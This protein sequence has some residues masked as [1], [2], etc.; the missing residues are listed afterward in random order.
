MQFQSVGPPVFPNQKE[1]TTWPIH[2]ARHGGLP[3]VVL[4]I[5]ETINQYRQAA[6][7]VPR[8]ALHPK[9]PTHLLEQL[10]VP[11]EL[12]SLKFPFPCTRCDA[13]LA[14]HPPQGVK[15]NRVR[16][17]RNFSIACARHVSLNQNFT[18]DQHQPTMARTV[19]Q[20]NPQNVT[21]QFSARRWRQGGS[22]ANFVTF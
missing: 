13:M 9:T 1:C 3:R 15:L 11:R 19:M 12:W 18:G 4:F 6:A 21:K 8:N 2:F 20:F 22:L 16:F 14:A 5:P 7:L 17:L 10:R